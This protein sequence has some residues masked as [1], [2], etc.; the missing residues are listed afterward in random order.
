MQQT[1]TSV[2]QNPTFNTVQGQAGGRTGEDASLVTLVL[3]PEIP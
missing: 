3:H 1:D 2:E